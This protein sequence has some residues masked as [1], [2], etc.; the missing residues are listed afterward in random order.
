MDLQINHTYH[1]HGWKS[2]VIYEFLYMLPIRISS[3]YG[4]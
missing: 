3:S 4:H 1:I 2:G